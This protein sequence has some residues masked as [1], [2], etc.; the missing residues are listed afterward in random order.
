MSQKK[1]NRTKQNSKKEKQQM[2]VARPGFSRPDRRKQQLKNLSAFLISMCFSPQKTLKWWQ[3]LAKEGRL[4]R[5]KKRKTA[6]LKAI[7]RRAKMFLTFRPTSRLQTSP[8]WCR[9]YRTRARQR[10]SGG[11]SS[12][13]M[14]FVAP[15]QVAGVSP[16]S[17]NISSCEA[18]P[19][20]H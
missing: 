16:G 19:R 15:F 11:G 14:H 8:S 7:R 4:E 12:P 10:G 5:E 9:R 17:L 3:I 13:E 6:T 2:F 1:Q 18:A 20:S